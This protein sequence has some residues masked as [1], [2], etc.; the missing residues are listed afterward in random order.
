[1][2]A[3]PNSIQLDNVS[4]D[5][6]EDCIRALLQAKWPDG[7][8]CPRC[9]HRRAHVISTRRLPLYECKACR[10]Q[11]SLIAGTIME[12]SRTPLRLWFQAIH[13]HAQ[14]RG[15]NALE[16]SRIIGVTYKT[17]WLICH[18]ILFAMS[19]AESGKP[20]DGIVRVTDAVIRNRLD[21][22]QDHYRQEQ[23][24]IIG[25]SENE[26]KIITRI[27]IE[28][29]DKEAPQGNLAASAMLPF[30]RR[31]VEH[32]AAI[33]AMQSLHI[34]RKRLTE[35]GR[36]A[37]AWLV[38]I[39]PKHLQRYLDNFC[40]KWNRRD[41]AVFGELLQ[42]CSSTPA[43]IYPVL[44]RGLDRS[45]SLSPRQSASSTRTAS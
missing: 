8:V 15:T 2:S 17:A 23:T 28:Y 27:R 10:K 31:H 42:H 6:E 36:S 3:Y 30:I 43:I 13:L 37:E 41:Q 5:S 45:S 12:G 32:K 25:A 4:I 44:T 34:G 11:T 35:I 22:I 40:Y 38:G 24:L 21:R 19:L 7:F 16:L 14:P 18:K 39:G 33:R 29:R 20:L 1:M 9:G 26:Q